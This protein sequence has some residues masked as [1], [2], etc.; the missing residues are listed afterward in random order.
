MLDHLRLSIPVLPIFIKKMG[1]TQIFNG[2]IRD[3]NLPAATRHVSRDLDGNTITGDLYSP[4]ESLPSSYTDMAMKFYTQSRHCPPYVEIKASPLKL[5]QGH[6]LYGFESIEL[7]AVEMLGLLGDAYPQLAAILDFA[8]IEVLHLDTTYYTKLPH[9]SMVQPVL[10]YLSS[11][12]TGHR[13]AK[14]LAY[15]NYITWG[16]DT[17]RYLRPKAYGKFEEMK[18]QMKKLQKSAD[19]GC[20]RSKNLVMIMHENLPLANAVVRFEGRVCKTY[21]TKNF[22][23]GTKQPYP[24]NLWALIELQKE[25]PKL[26]TDLWHVVFDPILETLKGKNML[27]A[28]DAEILDLL[29]SKLW[30]QNIKKS[31]RVSYVFPKYA[32]PRFNIS[33]KTFM[34]LGR[35]SYTKA[36]N[37]FKFYNLIRQMGTKKVKD[38]HSSSTYYDNLKALTSVGISKA[39][40]QNLHKS[41][42][43]KVVPVAQICHINFNNQ[44]PSHYVMPTS[45]YMERLKVA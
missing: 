5:L 14:K 21:L 45:R 34:L 9:Q 39:A 31:L 24:T 6:N 7:G 33:N 17:A 29:K 26:L 35:I 30:T 20:V 16:S 2:D 3:F 25:N 8:N 4:Y 13:K 1:D 36:N 32:T 42:E 11:C 10:D 19:T 18:A 43:G 23:P 44:L 28:D 12:S 15:E 41:P 40:L 27:Y 22:I 38:L 37:A